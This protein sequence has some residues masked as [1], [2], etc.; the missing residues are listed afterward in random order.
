MKESG[1]QT[2]PSRALGLTVAL[3]VLLIAAGVAWRVAGGGRPL[4]ESVSVGW[5]HGGSRSMLPQARSSGGPDGERGGGSG[6]IGA[7][8]AG[9]ELEP[10]DAPGAI[11]GEAL[12]TFRTARALELFRE[13]ANRG[14]FTV[15]GVEPRLRTVRVRFGD[16]ASLAADWAE[17]AEDYER[18]GPNY[19][20]RIP[21]LPVGETGRESR[22][23]SANEGG[24]RPFESQGLESIGAAGDRSRWGKGVTVAVVDSGIGSHPSLAGV[25]IRHIDLLRDGAEINGHGTAMASLIAGRDAGV[26]GVAPAATLLDIRVADADGMSNTALLASGMVKA[27]DLGARIINISLGTDGYS[28]MLVEA[29]RYAQARNVVIVAAAGNEQQTVLALP[30]ALPGVLSVG[31]VDAGGKQAWFSNSGEGLTLVAPGVGIVSGYTG[32]RLVIGSG[33]SQATALA[34][35]AVASLMSRGYSAAAIVP[36]LVRAAKPLEGPRAAVGAGLLQLPR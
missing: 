4:R 23:D 15:L 21:G 17:H 20:A 1:M 11:P 26:G 33:T 24:R 19:L 25:E 36:L 32:G 31:A 16:P 18:F 22:P 12:L 35:G 29:V 7:A 14:G 5:K 8:G 28:A 6:K 27:V 3:S 10:L 2:V 13:R 34:S 9:L 30:A